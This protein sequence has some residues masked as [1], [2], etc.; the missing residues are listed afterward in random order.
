MTKDEVNR[1]GIENPRQ[2]FIVVEKFGKFRAFCFFDSTNFQYKAVVS[3]LISI[4]LHPQHTN[5]TNKQWRS[6][7]LVYLCY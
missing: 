1:F 4:S 2:S 6:E 7:K 3:F 5:L